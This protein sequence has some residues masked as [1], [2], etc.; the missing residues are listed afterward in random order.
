MYSYIFA[1]KR[2]AAVGPTARRKRFDKA[3]RYERRRRRGSLL[4]CLAWLAGWVM[5]ITPT[6][7]QVT[8]RVRV[9]RTGAYTVRVPRMPVLSFSLLPALLLLLRL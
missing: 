4:G 9:P 3:R 5:C 6:G 1:V 7:Q 8:V 2:S